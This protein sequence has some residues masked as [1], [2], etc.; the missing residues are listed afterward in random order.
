MAWEKLGSTKIEGDTLGTADFSENYTTPTYTWTQSGSTVSVTSGVARSNNAGSNNGDRVTAPLGLTLS[1]TK[2]T[3]DF[4]LITSSST[5]SS[6]PITIQSSTGAFNTSSHDLIGI[7]LDANRIYILHK[8]GSGAIQT[9]SLQTISASTQYYCRLTRTSATEVVLKIYTDSARTVQHGSTITQSSLPST[10][11]GL[12]TIQHG[13]YNGGG[14]TSGQTW[15]VDNV[16]I[17]DGLSTIGT[18][19]DTISV[20]CGTNATAGTTSSGGT[21]N[22]TSGGST[23]LSTIDV[24]TTSD[25]KWVLRYKA[26]FGTWSANSYFHVCLSDNDNPITSSQDELGV[27]YRNDSS[28]NNF[29]VHTVAGANPNSVNSQDQQTWSTSTSTDYYFEIVRESS[30]SAKVNFYG[31]D[32]TYGTVSSTSS[33]TSVS[34]NCDGLDRIKIMVNSASN[35]SGAVTI[36]DIEFYNG[37]TEVT[38][39]KKHLMVNYKI[40]PSGTLDNI[41]VQFNSDTGPNYAYSVSVDGAAD[42]TSTSGSKIR[43]RSGGAVSNDFFGTLNIINNSSTEKLLTSEQIRNNTDGSGNVPSRAEHVGKWANTSNQ[44]TRVDLSQDGSGSFAEGSEVTVYG[45]D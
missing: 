31:T 38:S 6:A 10:V 34:A 27:L 16:N 7:L 12:T 43:F 37:I 13:S 41:A 15:D 32:S 33:Y 45:T 36:S 18:P 4:D 40:I 30:T 3:C 8:D 21:L 23:V 19:A 11:Q 1:N 44:I 17:Y 26:N 22:I 5:S 39:G 25:E 9:S 2:W 20:D 28:S 29:G 35:T 24:G 42:G 14:A